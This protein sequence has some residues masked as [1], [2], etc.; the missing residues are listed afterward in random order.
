MTMREHGQSRAARRPR[1]REAPGEKL[2]RSAADERCE[3]WRDTKLYT[4]LWG[5]LTEKIKTEGFMV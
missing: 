1:V 2:R 3:D 5:F 4:L